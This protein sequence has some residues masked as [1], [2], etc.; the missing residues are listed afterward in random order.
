MSIDSLLFQDHNVWQMCH[1]HDL[2]EF[3]GRALQSLLGSRKAI[4]VSL[5]SIERALRLA[6]SIEDFSKTNMHASI[7]LWEAQNEPYVCVR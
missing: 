3:F 6:Y 5:E 4:E 1:G 7:K 2:A